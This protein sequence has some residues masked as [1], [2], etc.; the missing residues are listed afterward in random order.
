MLYSLL[1]SLSDKFS[2]LHV[3]RFI[4]FRTAVAACTALIMCL[5]IGPYL[6]RALRKFQIGEEIRE[7]GPKSHFTK[8]G[9]PTMGGLLILASI[10]IPTL[11]WTDLNLRLVWLVLFSMAAFAALGFVDDYRKVIR[12]DKR[13]IP[14]S[15]KCLCQGAIGLAVGL[16]WARWQNRRA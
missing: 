5:L 4:T 1:L 7:D 6:I 12:K 8:Q 2:V 9:T 13:G 11:L 15:R 16:V 10:A 14:P 3:F